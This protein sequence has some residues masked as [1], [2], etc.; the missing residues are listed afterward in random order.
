MGPR[1]EMTMATR[2]KKGQAPDLYLELVRRLPLRPIRSDE[3]LDRAIRTI[4]SLIDRERLKLEEK[5]YLDV[6]SD[7]VERYETEHHPIPSLPD[8]ELLQHLIETNKTT[9]AEVARQTGIAESTISEVIGGK[10]NLSPGH[11]GKLAGF[12]GVQPGAFRFDG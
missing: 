4:D 3:E 10:R 5:D 11:I 6:L 12:F 7:L 8:G 1:E 2:T 9:Q